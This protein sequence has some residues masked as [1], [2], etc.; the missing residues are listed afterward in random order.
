MT[1]SNPFELY[2]DLVTEIDIVKTGAVSMGKLL[3]ELHTD[4]AFLEATGEGIETWQSFLAQPEIAM[5]VSE[6]NR[7]IQIYEQFVLRLGVDEDEL[8]QIPVKNLQYLLPIVKQ[9]ENDEE[10]LGLLNDAGSLSQRDFRERIKEYK[11]DDGVR[12]YT[13]IVMR[14]CNETSTMRKVQG[15]DSDTIKTALNIND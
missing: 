1:A 14:R 5:S 12:T 11:D 10:V 4:D 9:L 2:N 6:A 7:L 8:A 15:I 13:Y 3:Y